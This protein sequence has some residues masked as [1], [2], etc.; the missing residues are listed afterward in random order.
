MKCKVCGAES[1]KYPLCRNCNTKK[2]AGYIIKCSICGNWHYKNQQCPQQITNTISNADNFLYEPKQT[3]ITQSE[4]SFF[5]AIKRCVPENYLVFPQINLASFINRT[6]DSRYRNE[7][8]RNVDFLITDSEYHP[9]IVIEINDKSHLTHERRERDEKVKNICEEAGIPIITLWTSYGANDEYIKNRINELLNSPPAARIH[10]FSSQQAPSVE[11]SASSANV[12]QPV[13][14]KQGCYIATCVYG[15]YDCPQV[16]TLR[17][18]RDY[19]LSTVW[20]GRMFIKLY[21]T[22]SPVIVSIL[23]SN[24]Y[25]RSFWK[26]VLDK[27]V[28]HLNKSGYDDTPYDDM[29]Y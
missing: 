6:D 19:S 1:G 28:K 20:Y 4:Q 8:F 21:Y 25:F 18:Y 7:L 24:Y 23:G 5:E 14:K 22:V 9:K 11:K 26:T 17:R 15:S 10:H 2:E 12:Y 27:A 16:W 29:E 13:K 3:L